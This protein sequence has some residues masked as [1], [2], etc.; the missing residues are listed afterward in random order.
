MNLQFELLI[1]LANHSLIDTNL[2]SFDTYFSIIDFL[3]HGKPLYIKKILVYLSNPPTPVSGRD[4]DTSARVSG[5]SQIAGTS[6]SPGTGSV[7]ARARAGSVQ[8]TL[9]PSRPTSVASP[10]RRVVGEDHAAWQG[11]RR[12]GSI[13]TAGG[14]EGRRRA[15]ALAEA[16]RPLAEACIDVSIDALETG[17]G[18]APFLT[19]GLT[20]RNLRHFSHAFATPPFAAVTPTARRTTKQA[21]LYICRYIRNFDKAQRYAGYRGPLPPSVHLPR[22]VRLVPLAKRIFVDLVD[23]PVHPGRPDHALLGRAPP[24]REDVDLVYSIVVGALIKQNC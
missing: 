6:A 13:P 18:S 17:P 24:K 19:C 8:T 15:G 21:P 4:D 22:R 23:V 20:G 5:G 1:H 7:G 3:Y 9:P 11:A 12:R 16:A 10:L 2:A 14:G